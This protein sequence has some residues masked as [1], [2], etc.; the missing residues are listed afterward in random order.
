MNWYRGCLLAFFL[1]SGFLVGVTGVSAESIRQYDVSITPKTTGSFL[2]S[3]TI[4]YDFGIENRH[5]I[6]RDIPTSHSQPATAWYKKRFIDIDVK[7]VLRG[8][9]SEPFEVIENADQIRIKIGD[10][11]T[12][13]SGVQVYRIDYEV[14]GG[15][16]Y[17]DLDTPEIYWN[18]IGHQWKVPIRRAS[19]ELNDPEGLFSGVRS[20]YRGYLGEG[21]TC[22]GVTATS[23]KVLFTASQINPGEGLTIAQGMKRGAV[24]KVILEETQVWWFWVPAVVVW[25]TIVGVFIY[26]YRTAFRPNQAIIPR[27]EPFEDFNP[28]FTGL[29]IDGRLDA[30]DITAG[31]VYLAEQG[32]IKIKRTEQKVL[33]FFEIPDYEITLLKDPDDIDSEFLFQTLTLLFGHGMKPPSTVRLSDIKSDISDQRRNQKILKAMR[34]A[35]LLVLTNRGFFES[36][37]KLLVIAFFGAALLFTAPFWYVYTSD[38]L[39][40]YVTP[41]IIITSATAVML[42][43]MYKRRTKRGYDAL[44][45]LKGF[46][47]FLSVTEKERYAFHNAPSKNPEQFMKYL[48][49][50]IAFGVEDKWAAVFKDIT[51]PEPSWYDRGGTGQ[52]FSA[53]AFTNDISGFSQSFTQSSGS[54]GASGGGSVGGG[55]GGGG[56]GSW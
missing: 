36:G 30:R 4:A 45:H 56:G 18:A 5:G 21:G 35:A 50:A 46:K 32:Y 14:N 48:P 9:S 12:L 13:V 25:F 8:S 55:S 51:I 47:Q 26:R 17:Y 2:V 41:V 23:G 42:G 19:V 44:W 38:L 53:V 20:C 27:Y 31:I 49:Y 29:L 54:S 34:E 43:L 1:L 16:S 37:V 22:G 39:G 40:G 24:P 10:P 6:F 52:A 28:V 33:F 3:E 15:L 11:N 7:N